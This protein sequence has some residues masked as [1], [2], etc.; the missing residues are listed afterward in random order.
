VDQILRSFGATLFCVG[1]SALWCGLYILQNM[2]LDQNGA[3]VLA[4]CMIVCLIFAIVGAALLVQNWRSP[5][6][7]LSR[8]QTTTV[9]TI[10]VIPLLC[11]VVWMLVGIHE[12][13]FTMPH[14]GLLYTVW[15]PLVGLM[16]AVGALSAILK[17]GLSPASDSHRYR[18]A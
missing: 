15:A 14:R 7:E 13:Y 11:G 1:L 17:L 5:V 16:I 12:I 10:L 3:I 18:P 4:V 9:L 2:Q 8:R 6:A